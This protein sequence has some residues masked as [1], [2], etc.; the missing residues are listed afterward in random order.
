MAVIK[1]N[2][3]SL[4]APTKIN[5]PRFD[6]DSGDAK[7]N[8]AGYM[9]RDRVRQGI[10]KIELEWRMLT[11]SEVRRIESSIRPASVSVTFTTPEG[12]KTKRMYA[13]DRKTDMVVDDYW[14]MS[15]N[16]IEY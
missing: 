10:F 3:V 14:N 13:G 16:L 11:S 15:F 2:G 8:E 7:R 6:L 5:T 4:P 1:I 12:I 9:Q